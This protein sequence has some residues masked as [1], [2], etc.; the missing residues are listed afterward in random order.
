MD[1]DR[2]ICCGNPIP[3]GRM[4]CPRC[5]QKEIKYGSI[6]QSQ[7]ATT[8]EVEDAYQWLY[9]NIDETIDMY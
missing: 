6:L 9:A 7:N 3:E 4:V 2:C 1:V 8:Q 5:E